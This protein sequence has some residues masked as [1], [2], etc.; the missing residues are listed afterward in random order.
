MDDL[1]THLEL[2]W[3][4]S[5][6]RYW[7]SVLIGRSVRVL[8]S[9][10]GRKYR[11]NVAASVLRQK[12]GPPLSGRLSVWI[13]LFPPTRRAFDL[14][15]RLKSLLDAMQHAGVYLDDGQID[16]LLVD[17]GEVVKGTGKCIVTLVTIHNGENP[18]E[19]SLTGAGS[20]D[21]L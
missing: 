16:R 19:S 2:P 8:I 1:V 20:S 18:K 4:P 7:R 13:E 14:D 21:S 15:N 12:Q 11:T 9:K 10:N 5:V 6:N 3:P 17:R